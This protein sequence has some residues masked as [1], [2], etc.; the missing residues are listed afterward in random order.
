M[1]GTKQQIGLRLAQR[2]MARRGHFTIQQFTDEA[3]RIEGFITD[4]HST[5]ERRW[6][7]QWCRMMLWSLQ[8]QIDGN[9]CRLLPSLRA[10]IGRKVRWIWTSA[11]TVAK[12]PEYLKQLEDRGQLRMD[13]LDRKLAYWGLPPDSIVALHRRAIDKYMGVEEERAA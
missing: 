9:V 13:N 2:L 10:M 11:E 7:E 5:C 1:D 4:D 12:T 6:H 3:E 8:V